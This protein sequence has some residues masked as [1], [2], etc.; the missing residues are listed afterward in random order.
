MKALIILANSNL[1][2]PS[3]SLAFSFG[4]VVRP[5]LNQKSYAQSISSSPSDELSLLSSDVSDSEPSVDESS[6]V[7]SSSVVVS[8]F[9]SSSSSVSVVVVVEPT[10]DDTEDAPPH[11]FTV[12]SYP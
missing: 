2:R 1:V 5:L 4:C 12:Q 6:V 7:P 10:V 11:H 3:K 9:V 8:S